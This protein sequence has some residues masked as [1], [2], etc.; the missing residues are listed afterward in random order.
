MTWLEGLRPRESE[1]GHAP[2]S[3]PQVIAQ[4]RGQIGESATAW[5][6]E[7]AAEI[8]ERVGEE[9]SMAGAPGMITGSERESC[10]ACLLTTL[11]GLHSGTP[12]AEITAPES[13]QKNVRLSVRQGVP[14]GTVLRTVWAC[15]TRVQDALLSVLEREVGPC[16]LVT[17]V[18]DLN[19]ALFSYVSS[20]VRDLMAGYEDELS[21]WH[22]RLPAERLRIMTALLEGGDPPVD[23]EQVLGLRLGKH[24]LIGVAWPSTS[25]HLPDRETALNR[26]GATTGRLLGADGTLTLQHEGTTRFWWTFSSKPPG[27]VASI[28]HDA[29]RPPWMKLALGTVR[30]G[31][32]GLRGSYFDSLQ[33]AAI[34]RLASDGTFW[35]YEETGLLALLIADREAA[36]RFVRTELAGLLGQDPKTADIRETLRHYLL[37]GSSRVAAAQALHLATNTVA[38]RVKRAAQQLDR[39]A[40]ERTMQTLMALEL[41]HIFPQLLKP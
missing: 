40:G 32:A 36:G 19:A 5:A 38:Y 10:E 8:V 2:A 1:H 35:S 37:S 41:V 33:A 6:A 34:G 39:P 4:A 29:P 11:I 27:N 25:G 21:L 3:A 12:A 31:L 16:R 22:G 18:R 13:A 14:I 23:A 26:Y 30:P 7:A 20:Y 24:H 15:H 9:F 28:V 17:E